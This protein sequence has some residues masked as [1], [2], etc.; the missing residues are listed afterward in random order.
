MRKK[1]ILFDLT[2][3][4]D[5]VLILFFSVLLMNTEQISEY[6]YQLREAEEHR[7]IAVQELGEAEAELLEISMRLDALSEWDTERL[8]FTRELDAQAA[9]RSAVEEAIYFVG[10]DLQTVDGRRVLNISTRA[11]AR[12]EIEV[13]WAI[14]GRNIIQ[15][16]GFVSSEIDRIL[17]GIAASL[18]NERPILI[19]F[20]ESSIAV[21]EF[22]L[23]NSNIELFAQAN[24]EFTILLSV[25]RRLKPE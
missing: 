22:N 12:E 7:M 11:S 3:L 24:L 2:P 13:I 9:W 14:D 17:H 23:I 1:E 15:N 16:A 18:P 20:D 5:V 6:L 21:Q 25:Y 4:L 19:M 8:E 10:M